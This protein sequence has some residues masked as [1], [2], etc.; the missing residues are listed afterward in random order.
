[1]GEK[2]YKISIVVT[3]HNNEKTVTDCIMSAIRQTYKDIELVLVDD[4]SMDRSGKICDVSAETSGR[5]KVIHKDN[6]GVVSAWKAGVE[7]AEGDYISFLDGD[8]QLDPGMIED[9]ASY[10]TG[11]AKEIVACDYVT[12]FPDGRKKYHWNELTAGEY[13]TDKIRSVI[14]PNLA[15]KEKRYLQ[16]T[17]CAKLISKQL[18]MD[19]LSYTDE[20]IVRGEDL[21]FMLA[22]LSDT[23]RICVLD[24]KAYYHHRGDEFQ[25]G[26]RYD[27][28]LE[29]SL[30]RFYEAAGKVVEEKFTGVEKTFR[31]Q[32]LDTEYLLGLFA[33]IRNEALWNKVLYKVNIQKKASDP[34]VKKLLEDLKP[35]L[36]EKENKTAYFVLKHPNG[37]VLSMYR[38]H[39]IAKEKRERNA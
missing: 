14:I 29:P 37:A 19:N 4:G 22:I 12:E 3:V 28:K 25:L 5:T 2:E 10:L 13:D 15:G 7:A 27:T 6:G 39:L 16:V 8:D 11:S 31:R 35:E 9:M 23:E 33:V 24:R 34:K 17:R 20:K 21:L 1:M 36:T 30:E 26:T 32:Q 38:S 18:I